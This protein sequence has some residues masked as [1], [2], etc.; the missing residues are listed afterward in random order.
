MNY[1]RVLVGAL[2][3]VLAATMIVFFITLGIT[4]AELSILTISELPGAFLLVIHPFSLLLS[5][6]WSVIAALAAGGFI[7]GLITK[8]YRAGAIAGVI[9]FGLMMFLQFAVGCG[10]NVAT[11]QAWWVLMDATGSVVVDIG[12]GIGIV[13]VTGA[14]GGMLTSGKTKTEKKDTAKDESK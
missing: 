12:L 6:T 8:N 9:G 7:G 5:G 13:I 14:V 1:G 3:C 2:F 11:F 10:F 4:V